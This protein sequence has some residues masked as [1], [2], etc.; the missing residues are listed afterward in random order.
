VLIAERPLEELTVERGRRAIRDLLE[1]V[2]GDHR[3]SVWDPGRRQVPVASLLKGDIVIAF[4][5]EVDVPVDGGGRLWATLVSQ[6]RAQLLA[7]SVH[8]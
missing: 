5:L 6:T 3:T 8:R 7:E 1:F 2:A 4:A